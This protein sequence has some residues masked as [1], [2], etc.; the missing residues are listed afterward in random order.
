MISSQILRPRRGG[1][2]T[3]ELLIVIVVLGIL[4][5]FAMPRVDV[6]SHRVETTERQ[7][8]L[9][10]LRAQQ[11]AVVRQHDVNVLFDTAAR[12]L[13][14]HAD[15]NGNRQRDAGEME[16]FIPLEPGVEFIRGAAPKGPPGDSIIGFKRKIGQLPVLT[17]HRSG[18]ASEAGG[19][20]V[21]TKFSASGQKPKQARAL[22]VDRGTGLVRRFQLREGTWKSN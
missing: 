1:F 16:W 3:L 10:L 22:V 19:F 7:L 8:A 11:M 5:A 14:L 20:Y 15:V 9:T 6:L 2:T 21:G 17:Y 4:A 12:R 13:I 18:S